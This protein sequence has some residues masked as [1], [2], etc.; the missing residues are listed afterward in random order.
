MCSLCS[1]MAI[2]KDFFEY[3]DYCKDHI[4]TVLKW[5]ERDSKEDGHYF[6]DRLNYMKPLEMARLGEKLKCT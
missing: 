5:V 6:S 4:E 1:K 2:I 3:G